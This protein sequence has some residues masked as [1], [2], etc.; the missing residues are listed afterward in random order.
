MKKEVTYSSMD[1]FQKQCFSAGVIA[2]GALEHVTK[3]LQQA[4]IVRAKD[5]TRAELRVL[6][7]SYVD[8]NLMSMVTSATANNAE[9]QGME[10]AAVIRSIIESLTMFDD[11]MDM[12]GV[13]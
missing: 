5:P 12:I 1:S 6:Y 10:W 3:H 9:G 7:D 13:V 4:K 11:V 8:V 2:G